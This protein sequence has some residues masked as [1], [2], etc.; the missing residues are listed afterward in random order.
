MAYKNYDEFAKELESLLADEVNAEDRLEQER[1]KAE[2]KEKRRQRELAK[3]RKKRRNFLLSFLF[4]SL[5]ILAG[6][7][8]GV[9]LYQNS[10]AYKVCRVEAGGIVVPSDFLKKQDENAVFTA[11]SDV[12]DTKIPGKYYVE[13]KTGSFTTSS[14]LIVEDTIAP[15]IELC[16]IKMAYGETC[17]LDDFITKLQDVTAVS[18]SYVQEPDFS[19]SGEQTVC[20]TVVDLGGNVTTKDTRLWLMPVIPTVHVELGSKLPEA[21]ELVIE[22]VTAEYVFANADC[23]TV[24]TYTVIV[25]ADGAEY[26]VTLVVEDT[27]EPD[28]VLKAVSDFALIKKSPQDFV[29]S[30]EDLSGIAAV[31]FKTEP[32]FTKVGSQ[33]VVIVVEDSFGN[34]TEKETVLEL[35]ADDEAPIFT[36]AEDF[37]VWLGD[38]VA[39]KSKVQV[40][41][42]CPADVTIKVDATGVNLKSIGKYP[43]VYTAT[44]IAGNS[45]KITLTVYVKSSY[46]DEEELYAKVDSVF[47]EIFLDGMTNRERCQAIYDYIRKNV[48]YISNSDKGDY[49]RAAMEGLTKGKG[50]CYVYFSLSKVM[51]DRAGFPNI[52]IERIQVGDSM[53]FWN[54][55]DIGDGHGWYHFDTTPRRLGNPYIFLWDDATLMEYSDSH[56]GTHNYDRSLYP[57]IK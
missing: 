3:K 22:G 40:S 24:G 39:Y 57:E 18:C 45:T 6:G 38:T 8:A 36:E 7:I 42:N 9:V 1:R 16:E 54:L 21:S 51:L 31:F 5:L 26:E 49:I 15:V 14:V 29:V 11:N 47:E 28:L 48:S 33:Q 50:D 19:L 35:I 46:V 10:L 4:F 25:L 55:V 17:E 2:I 13:V 12:I 27:T 56:E 23:N 44:D 37:I 32:D 34:Q 20:I 43:V 52:D 41:D 53:H 30:A